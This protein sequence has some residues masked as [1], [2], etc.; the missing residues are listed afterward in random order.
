MYQALFSYKATG[1][2]LLLLIEEAEGS[3]SRCHL[4]VA[5]MQVLVSSSPRIPPVSQTPHVRDAHTH[6]PGKAAAMGRNNCCAGAPVGLLAL[7]SQYGSMWPVYV[8]PCSW[9]IQHAM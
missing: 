6:R 5:V 9:C 4:A 1:Q 2:G 7:G 3:V 8:R